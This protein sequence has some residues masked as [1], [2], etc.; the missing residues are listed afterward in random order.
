MSVYLRGELASCHSP[1]TSMTARKRP[2]ARKSGKGREKNTDMG[3]PML[4][5]PVGTDDGIDNNNSPLICCLHVT[6]LKAFRIKFFLSHTDD[7]RRCF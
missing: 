4:P 7:L 2:A 3:D 6:P 1:Y 5:L